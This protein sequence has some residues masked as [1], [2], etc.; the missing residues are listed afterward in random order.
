M[1]NMTALT[2]RSVEPVLAV[3]LWLLVEFETPTMP[4]MR[5]AIRAARNR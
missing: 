3:E 1:R 5:A 4:M 2:F